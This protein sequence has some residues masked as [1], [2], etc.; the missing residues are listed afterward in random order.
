VTSENIEAASNWKPGDMF[1]GRDA[2]RYLGGEVLPIEKVDFPGALSG[3]RRLWSV[4]DY[5]GAT[6]PTFT[7]RWGPDDQIPGIL[8]QGNGVTFNTTRLFDGGGSSSTRYDY[9][10]S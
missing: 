10:V 6:T 2:A 7:I 5:T 1:I 9:V 3:T 4:I 8:I